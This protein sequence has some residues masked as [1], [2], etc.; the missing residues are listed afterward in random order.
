MIRLKMVLSLLLGSL[1]LVSVAQ[2]ADK[3]GNYA[4]KGLGILTC[5]QLDDA[6]KK[7]PE[8]LKL[9]FHTYLGG[10]LTAFNQLKKGT[11]DILPWQNTENFGVLV[12]N[13]CTNNPDLQLVLALGRMTKAFESARLTRSTEL[14]KISEGDDFVW[15]YK[16]VIWRAQ[17]ALKDRGYYKWNPDALFGPGTRKAFKGFQKDND[18][19]VTGLPD[20]ITLFKLLLYKAEENKQAE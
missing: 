11:F 7:N 3:K 16:T 20:Q 10:Y 4:A 2:A 19:K 18:L 13:Y 15:I 9:M 5:A 17:K 8:K 6:S 1:L 14:V 12:S